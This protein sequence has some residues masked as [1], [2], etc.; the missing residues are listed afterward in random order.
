V[1]RLSRSEE[2]SWEPRDRAPACLDC[3]ARRSAAGSRGIGCRRASAAALGGAPLRVLAMGMSAFRRY[4]RGSE[5]VVERGWA[6][7]SSAKRSCRL[8]E[9][10]SQ[11]QE[12]GAR[13][14][15]A[16]CVV[17][18]HR[19]RRRAC[20]PSAGAGSGDLATRREVTDSVD[21]RWRSTWRSQPRAPSSSGG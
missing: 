11:W 14:S 4:C 3:R 8:R 18:R 12:Q 2:R 15:I 5:A 6:E 10:P 16:G 1:P 13:K 17:P 7:P 21:I 20:R 19:E 9:H